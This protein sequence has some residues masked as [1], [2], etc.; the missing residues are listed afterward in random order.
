MYV[1]STRASA[2][3]VHDEVVECV[4]MRNDEVLLDVHEVVSGGSAQFVELLSQ[5]LQSALQEL[6]DAVA[7]IHNTQF[8]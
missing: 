5:L 6:V 7:W 4:V 1:I 8:N 3:L 2:H